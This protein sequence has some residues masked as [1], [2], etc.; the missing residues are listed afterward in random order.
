MIVSTLRLYIPELIRRQETKNE[1]I[2]C[3][4]AA[5]AEIIDGSGDKHVKFWLPFGFS[6]RSWQLTCRRKKENETAATTRL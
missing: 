1:H 6:H 2:S 3:L 4:V 5:V